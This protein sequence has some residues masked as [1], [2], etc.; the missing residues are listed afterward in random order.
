VRKDQQ[1]KVKTI[2][3][4]A[5]RMKGEIGTIGLPGEKRNHHP[6]IIVREVI[7]QTIGDAP[8]AVARIGVGMEKIVE[9]GIDVKDIK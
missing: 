4:R 6:A 9:I 2:E 8:E 7:D 3:A 5:V 1:G